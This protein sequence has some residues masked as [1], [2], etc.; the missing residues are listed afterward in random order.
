MLATLSDA[1]FDHSD[2]I[3]EIKW[4]GYRAIADLTKNDIELY[5][6]NGLSFK[7]LY[8]SIAES[9]KKIKANV[10]LDGEI[11]V[12]NELGKPDFQKLQQFGEL[13]KGS[14]VYYVFDCLAVD[15]KPITDLPLLKRKEIVKKLLPKSDVIR[16]ADHIPEKGIEFFE[17]AKAM[18]LEGIIAKRAS[19]TYHIGKRT[20]DW[21]KIKNH[22]IQEAIIAGFTKPKGS[23]QYFGALLLAIYEKGQLKYIGHTGTGFSNRT[24]HDVYQKLK[25]LEIMKSPFPIKI[26]PNTAVTWVKPEL[27]CN[28]KFTEITQGGILRHPVFMGLRVDKSAKEADHL[29]VIPSSKNSIK[30]TNQKR[31]AKKS[32]QKTI[33]S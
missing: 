32:K 1:A 5:S 31:G 21:L 28:I 16:Y 7:Q 24:L 11:I 33:L 23:R 4:D 14:L 19:S 20:A 27:V 18:D 9:L 26:L 13:K 29:E 6:R 30:K 8:P 3:F 17:S 15:G 22:N 2:W 25:P 12:F 10:V